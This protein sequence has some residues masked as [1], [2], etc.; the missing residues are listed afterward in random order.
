MSKP[1]MRWWG[2]VRQVLYA[3]PAMSNK[4][5]LTDTERRERGAVGKAIE[6][7]SVLPGG[8]ITLGIVEKVFFQRSH[9]LCG[10]AMAEHVSFI[11][12]RRRQ[13]EFILSVG[14]HLNLP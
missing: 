12:A 11:T 13:R 1:R 10:A 3:Y 14:K 5:E 9:T 4:S 8:E 7:T 6:E 2:Y